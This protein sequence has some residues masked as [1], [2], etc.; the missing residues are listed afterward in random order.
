M[1]KD[2]DRVQPVTIVFGSDK[3]YV[4]NKMLH[5]EKHPPLFVW[6]VHLL[7]GELVRDEIGS[8]LEVPRD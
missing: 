3:F 1:E 4:D 5:K 6:G 7:I 2:W 8:R